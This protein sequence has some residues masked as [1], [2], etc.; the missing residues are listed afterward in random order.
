[1]SHMF[2][3]ITTNWIVLLMVTSDLRVL[4]LL[5]YFTSVFDYLYVSIYKLNRINL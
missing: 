5:K 2:Q 4:Y 1:M 3:L